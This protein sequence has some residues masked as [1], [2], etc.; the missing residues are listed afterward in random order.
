MTS[1]RFHEG[2]IGMG[3][4]GKPLGAPRN[5]TI[6][7][8]T[9]RAAHHSESVIIF[10]KSGPD[11]TSRQLTRKT[12]RL[13]WVDTNFESSHVQRLHSEVLFV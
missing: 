13:G 10:W 7:R 2:G 3:D 11:E 9:S 1:N 12:H 8:P 5:A 4:R 6:G